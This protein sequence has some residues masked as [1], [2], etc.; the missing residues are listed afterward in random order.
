MREERYIVTRWYRGRNED[1]I[2]SQ[3]T[4]R[5]HWL[6]NCAEFFAKLICLLRH[7]QFADKKVQHF[8]RLAEEQAEG[9]SVQPVQ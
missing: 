1:R 6:A 8:R 2:V 3:R 7:R 4:Y 5:W 9:A